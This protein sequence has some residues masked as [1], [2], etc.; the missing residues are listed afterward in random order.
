MGNSFQLTKVKIL[1]EKTTELLEKAINAWLEENSD[2][3]A[4]QGIQLASLPLQGGCVDCM[5]TAMITYK[6]TLA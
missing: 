4:L 5:A 1:S 3:A 2:Q 6:I